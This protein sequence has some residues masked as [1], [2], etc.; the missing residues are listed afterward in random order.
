MM[1]G[2]AA[3]LDWA[4]GRVRHADGKLTAALGVACAVLAVLWI[5]APAPG[6]HG[7]LEPRGGMEFLFARPPVTRG[8]TIGRFFDALP[9]DTGI[10]AAPGLGPEIVY[11]TDK[12]VVGIP[13]DPQLLDRFLAEYRIS[14][15]V[16]STEYW[17]QYRSAAADL[18]TGHLAAR[19]IGQHPERYRL[20]QRVREQY[21]AFYPAGDY[22]VF[23]VIPGQG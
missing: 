18:W 9:R 5:A 10:M 4:G 2:A 16:T 17:Q 6:E 3:C 13:F 12:R 22:L 20:V 23:Q 8:S 11:L 21:P 15:I 1:Q 14:Y 7:L 19:Y